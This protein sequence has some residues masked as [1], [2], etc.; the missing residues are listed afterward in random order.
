MENMSFFDS[1]TKQK[2]EREANLKRVKLDGLGLRF[3]EE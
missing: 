3:V 2:I 1:N